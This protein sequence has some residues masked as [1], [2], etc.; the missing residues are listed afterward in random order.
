MHDTTHCNMSY[1]YFQAWT[2]STRP[3][4]RYID[5]L[6]HHICR[7]HFFDLFDLKVPW[8]YLFSNFGITQW[9]GSL[10]Q[11]ICSSDCDAMR[12]VLGF[13]NYD[14]SFWNL[15][16]LWAVCRS[17]RFQCLLLIIYDCF[18]HV[19]S[20]LRPHRQ[21]NWCKKSKTCKE[22]LQSGFFCCFTDHNFSFPVHIL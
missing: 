16:T 7:D 10:F 11:N 4:V 15:W 17:R 14:H 22:I 20:R 2:R 8:L 5:Y 21:L 6:L 13:W 3:R 1:I 19:I 18:R 9:M 12:W